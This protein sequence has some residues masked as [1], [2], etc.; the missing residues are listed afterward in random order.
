MKSLFISL[1]AAL[2]LSACTWETYQI[3]DGSTHF[4]QR[5]PNGT[6]IYYTNGA[7]SQ[8]THY[9]ENRPQPHAILPNKDAE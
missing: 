6:G 7:A 3:E 9:H 2:A 8:N 4:R 5:Y 1:L